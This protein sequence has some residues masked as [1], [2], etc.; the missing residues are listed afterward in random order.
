MELKDCAF[1]LVKDI[2]GTDDVNRAF[3]GA[4]VA[5]LVGAKP[6][7]PGSFLY[8]FFVQDLTFGRNGTRRPPS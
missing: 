3:E 1:P 5:M 2:V 7:G 8:P 6:R 4:N